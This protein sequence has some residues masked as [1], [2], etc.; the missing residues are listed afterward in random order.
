MF[1]AIDERLLQ[2]TE[3]KQYR[4]AYLHSEIVYRVVCIVRNGKYRTTE[5]CSINNNGSSLLSMG[6]H[7]SAFALSLVFSANVI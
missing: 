4:K 6:N 3:I 2:N 1:T 5:Q 7:L